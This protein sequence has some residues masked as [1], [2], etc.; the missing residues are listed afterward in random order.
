MKQ[1]KLEWLAANLFYTKRFAVFVGRRC[2]SLTIKDVAEETRL[3]WKTSKDLEAQYLR[4]QVRR[5]GMPAPKVV[6]IDEISI[7]KGHT[8]RLVVSDVERRRP[9]WFGGHDRSET[10]MDEFYQWLGSTKSHRIRLAVMDMWK[11][12]RASTLKAEHAPHAA[13]LFD[14]FHVLRHLDAALDTVRQTA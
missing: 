5:A 1:E 3:D 13:I 4:E 10:S 12:F 7:R 8:S 11:P 6:G 9:I 14:K 2:R